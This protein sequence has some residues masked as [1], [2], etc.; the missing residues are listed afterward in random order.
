MLDAILGYDLAARGWLAAYHAP[1]LDM[2]MVALSRAA[3]GGV[4]WLAFGVLL[5]MAR[6]RMAAG[7]VQMALALVVTSLLVGGVVKPAVARPR[8]YEALTD[9]R[10]I[11]V[12]TDSRSFPSSHAAN[13][14]A[15][16]YALA[17]LVPVARIPIWILALAVG[18]SRIYVG[19]HYPLDVA[20]GALLGL[21]CGVFVVG[22]SRWYSV[23]SAAPSPPVPR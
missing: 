1:V 19:V 8:P 6:P 2:L 17:R 5:V 22:G 13:A 10:V 15:A 18:F 4:L 7:V 21:G 16:A 20:A 11:D 3:R 14:C 23:R 12:P 9:V